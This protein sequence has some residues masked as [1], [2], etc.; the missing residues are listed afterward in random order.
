MGR[1]GNGGGPPERAGTFGSS[2]GAGFVGFEA[3]FCRLGKGG[4]VPITGTGGC[5]RPDGGDG[6]VLV[7]TFRLGLTVFDLFGFTS[8]S[9]TESCGNGGGGSLGFG[10][11][12][13]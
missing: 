8:K 12:C 2:F 13:K 3:A 11:Y 9:Y 6:A 5:G 7:A 10:M 1:A 4:G